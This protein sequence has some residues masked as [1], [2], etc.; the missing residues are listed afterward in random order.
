MK[1]SRLVLSCAIALPLFTLTASPARADVKTREKGQVKF[2]GM[3]GTM[4]RMF[5]GKAASEGLVST[6]AV[7]GNRKATIN[8]STGRIVD[9]GEEKIYDLDMKKKE[10]RVTTFEELRRKLREAQERAT[11]DAPKETGGEQ[12]QQPSGKEV[13]FDFDVKETGQTK[14]IAGYDTRQVIM[15]VTVREKGRKLEDSG[16]IVLTSDSWLGPDVP[17]MK[18]LVDFE[19]RYWKAIAPETASIS[20][21]QMAAVT[22][23]Y[24]MIKQAMDR[25]NQEKVNMKGTLLANALTFEGV[26]SK[27]QMAQQSQDSGGG[28]LGGML[29]RRVMKKDDKPRA[30]ILTVNSETLEVAT[31]VAPADVDVPAGFKLKN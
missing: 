24:P 20:A 26:K 10:Y 25:L 27:E 14:S 5:G 16:G 11:K 31:T 28:G 6:N 30:T 17:A 15:T 18:E 2:E 19:M 3:L 8:E 12:P 13:E 7:K 21:E 9:L 23:L 29:A 22:A 4:M 1:K